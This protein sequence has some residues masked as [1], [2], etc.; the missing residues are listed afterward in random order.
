MLLALLSMAAQAQA[1][2]YFVRQTGSNSNS[3]TSSGSAWLT[4]GY[5]ADH[6]T[7]G[8]TIYVGAGTYSQ[9]IQPAATCAGTA[10]NPIRFSA[11]T[12]GS[13]TGDAGAV[14]L[15]ATTGM[16]LYLDSNGHDYLQFDGFKIVGADS[17]AI[18]SQNST[19]IVFDH[20][21]VYGAS[22][23][24]LRFDT[25]QVTIRN[26]SF[27][28]NGSSG[29]YLYSGATG[30]IEDTS[31]AANNNYAGMLFQSSVTATVNRCHISGNQ[32][33]GVSVQGSTA[34]LTNCLIDG[35]TTDGI[36]V[37]YQSSNAV[38][39]QNCTIAGS[40]RYGLYF[41]AGTNTVTNCI[42]ANSASNGFIDS[43]SSTRGNNL[44]HGNGGGDT[45]ANSTEI[46][47]D[48]QFLGSGYKIPGA[49]PAAN[50]GTDLTGTV[51]DDLDGRA[52]PYDNLWDIGCYEAGPVGHWKMSEGSGTSVVDSSGFGHDATTMGAIWTTDCAGN[53]ALSFDGAGGIAQTN[54]VFDPP[55]E[56]SVAFWM[57]GSGPLTARQRLFGLNGNWEVR[58]ETDG[59][60][61]FD[62]GASP[63]AGNEP[64]TTTTPVD[65]QDRWYHVVAN[66]NDTDNS[67]AVYVDGELQTSGI[68][69]VNLVPQNGAILSF[70]TRTGSS[71]YW[72][73][74]LRDVRI[75]SYQ[76][77]AKEIAKLYGLVGHWKLDETSG[78]VA[79]DATALSND[80]EYQNG[81]LLGES[82]QIDGAVQFD[83]VDDRVEIPD[84]PYFSSHAT[85]GMTV[86]A[87]VKVLAVNTDSHAQTRQP[88]VA[89]GNS[90][91]WEW[92]LYV[93]DYGGAGFSSWQQGG[94]SH[95][96]IS[97]GTLPI[98]TW[99]HVAAT[100]LDG[101][102]NRVYIDGVE[103]ALGT[104]FTGNA[105]DG[106]RPVLVGAREDGQYLNAVIDDVRIYNRALCPTEIKQLFNGAVYPG[107]RIIQWVELR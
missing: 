64:F 11:D 67:F 30:T 2:D 102:S 92:A 82:G 65:Q 80:G 55:S 16:V 53:T 101:I 20:C 56:G 51:D 104:S 48:P 100:F 45:V 32:T 93:Y 91:F 31:I 47:A 1:I 25:Y 39:V 26:C 77:T 3:G 54:G 8:D 40:G 75:Y 78:T 68:S 105:Y 99:K 18:Y 94:S 89:K 21:E 106:D 36:V 87:W 12:D 96:E 85:I 76:L 9:P 60:L 74:A 43:S 58:Q 10:A 23:N 44:L 107:V 22:S 50:A 13:Q 61:K 71:E 97:G 38:L 15:T 86:S 19:G 24:G 66:F 98:G 88:I 6:V 42:V 83:G 59:T 17:H 41:S 69:P 70:G 5:A 81:P 14:V 90:G 7:A 79:A 63:Y 4:V 46:V 27:H 62:L 37:N 103:V 72:Q 73:G 84:Q 28:D 57:R 29:I 35:N 49:S 52:R 95:S 33:N 34:T